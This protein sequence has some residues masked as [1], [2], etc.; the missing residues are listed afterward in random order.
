MRK[1]RYGFSEKV[2]QKTNEETDNEQIYPEE[3]A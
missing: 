3:S 1:P 2:K